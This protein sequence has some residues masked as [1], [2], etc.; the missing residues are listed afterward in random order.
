MD[1]CGLPL[2]YTKYYDSRKSEEHCYDLK[3]TINRFW[4]GVGQFCHCSPPT[5]VFYGK[6]KKTLIFIKHTAKSVALACQSS[7]TAS[8]PS[9][10][11]KGRSELLRMR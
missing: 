3:D 4:V 1:D 2:Y 8:K 7:Q 9:S 6:K 5:T 10:L 11:S